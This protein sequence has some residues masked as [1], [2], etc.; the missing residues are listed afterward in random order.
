M[1]TGRSAPKKATR[2]ATKKVAKKKVATKKAAKK[3]VATKKVAKKAAPRRITAK[4][5]VAKK[6]APRRITAKKALANTRK[7]LKQ[8][9]EQA[10]EAPPWQALDVPHGS[11]QPGF[12]SEQARLKAGELHEGEARLDAIHG[13]ASTVDRHNQGKRDQR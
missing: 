6:A 7:L 13:S 10:R 4:K 5:K 2:K 3:K 9:Q 1:P 11:P 12:Q 8:K